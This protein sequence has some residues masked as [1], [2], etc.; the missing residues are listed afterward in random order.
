M[1]NSTQE[2]ILKDFH[3]SLSTI[4]KLLGKLPKTRNQEQQELLSKNK[5]IFKNFRNKDFRENFVNK[6]LSVDTPKEEYK[7]VVKMIKKVMT[8]YDSTLC[9][10]DWESGTE[11]HHTIM[12]LKG[13]IDFI[14]D[15]AFIYKRIIKSDFPKDE[16]PNM[17]I[18]KVINLIEK[19]STNITFDPNF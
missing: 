12:D 3:K 2:L 13:L 7:A 10:L 11:L 1:L 5:K 8:S 16:R 17:K 19:N 14:A 9:Y 18:F 15:K 4:L 6:L